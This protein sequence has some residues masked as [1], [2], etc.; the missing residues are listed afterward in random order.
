MLE[1][2]IELHITML[3]AR[4]AGK[5]SLLASVY[6]Q[7]EKHVKDLYLQLTPDFKTSSVLRDKLGELESALDDLIVSGPTGGGVMQTFNFGIGIPFKTVNFKLI[8]R[9]YPGGWVKDKP[10]EVISYIKKSDVIFWAIDTAALVENRGRFCEAINSID[11][12]T[13]F[14]KRALKEL[15]C[16]QKKL[17]LLVP[18]KCEK[19]MRNTDDIKKLCLLIEDKWSEFLNLIKTND[20]SEERFALAITPVQ[21]LGNVQYAYTDDSDADNPKFVFTR[22]SKNH[23]YQPKHVEQVLFYSLAF[24][25]RRYMQIKQERISWLDSMKYSWYRFFGGKPNQHF[26]AAVLHLVSHQ[27][28]NEREGFKILH[29]K[30]LLEPPS[31]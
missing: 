20:P 30:N 28:R 4:G 22:T 15:P 5:T 6:G 19:Y 9:D 3:G 26:G 21:T 8:F 11:T 2:N 17:I 31:K 12:I 25:V 10:T 7:F 29:G 16:D 18:I 13:D 23:P 14:F 24:L 27:N 1:N